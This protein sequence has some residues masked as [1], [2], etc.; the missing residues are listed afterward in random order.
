MDKNQDG[1]PFKSRPLKPSA[2]KPT[3]SSSSPAAAPSGKKALA[4]IPVDATAPQN[5]ARLVIQHRF[6]QDNFKTTLVFAGELY[7]YDDGRYFKLDPDQV[8]TIISRFID[9]EI[10]LTRGE[11][12]IVAPTS[13]HVR[14]TFAALREQVMLSRKRQ[15]PCWLDKGAPPWGEARVLNVAN[16]ILDPATDKLYPSDP[17]WFALGGV[18]ARHDPEATYPQW[19]NFLNV[20]WADDQESKDCLAEFMGATIMGEIRHQKIFAIKGPSRAGKGVIM[21]VQGALLGPAGTAKIGLSD[22]QSQF[23]LET[24]IGRPAVFVA[25]AR[26]GAN[27]DTA[28]AIERLLKISGGDNPSIPRKFL[29]NYEGPLNSQFWLSFNILPSL[30]DGDGSGALPNRFQFLRLTKSFLG[31]ED[32]TL[33]EKKLKPELDGILLYALA[34]WR[35]LQARGHFFTPES[36]QGLAD[37]NVELNSALSEFINERCLLHPHAVCPKDPTTPG[38]DPVFEAYIAWAEN[39]KIKRPMTREWFYRQ[40]ESITGIDTNF[41]RD[42]DTGTTRTPHDQKTARRILGIYGRHTTPRR[43]DG[44]AIVEA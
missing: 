14:E 24:I 11:E 37:Q 19:D 38:Q 35:R 44:S 17:R 13:W 43:W 34:G 21:S 22:L 42:P 23:G 8:K 4:R 33:F 27:A 40:L 5:L 18:T 9:R 16:G 26:I 39:R 41:R 31:R 25:D 3:E 30:R 15:P 29:P 1:N 10:Q 28:V 2:K 12:K 36:A 7:G 32:P 6:T 20:L